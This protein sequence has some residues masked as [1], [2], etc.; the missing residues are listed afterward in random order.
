MKIYIERFISQI[1]MW[2]SIAQ[3]DSNSGVPGFALA[4]S[5]GESHSCIRSR[6]GGWSIPLCPGVYSTAIRVSVYLSVCLSAR[7]PRCRE[8][9]IRVTAADRLRERERATLAGCSS[10]RGVSDPWHS[11]R[12]KRLQVLY[13]LARCPFPSHRRFS[14]VREGRSSI[15]PHLR[16]HE[17]SLSFLPFSF[18]PISYKMQFYELSKLHLF[19]FHVSIPR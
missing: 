14:A 9:S 4:R 3:T 5:C 8:R 7:C 19:L 17:N 12:Q 16:D 6:N 2:S 1:T 15:F 13:A 18:S 10:S 11:W